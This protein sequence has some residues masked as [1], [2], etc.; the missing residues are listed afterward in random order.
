VPVSTGCPRGAAARSATGRQASGG[1]GAKSQGNPPQ[2]RTSGPPP[3]AR[4]FAEDAIRSCRPDHSRTRAQRTAILTTALAKLGEFEEAAEAG[5]RAV[6]DAWRL[7]YCRVLREV[8][9]LLGLVGSGNGSSSFVEQAH[10]LLAASSG[11]S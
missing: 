5:Q 9:E 3:T 2:C 11:F 4:A 1:I 6:T 10:E 8:S 7:R